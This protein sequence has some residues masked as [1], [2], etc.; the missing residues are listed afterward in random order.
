[1]PGPLPPG[2][3]IPVAFSAGS[4]LTEA[5]LNQ[6]QQTLLWRILFHTH[7]G[8]DGVK[9]GSAALQDGAVGT[10]QMAMHA[11]TRD[12]LAP[13][14][15]GAAELGPAAVTNTH[16]AP[17]AVRTPSIA[18]DQVTLEKLSPDIR[19]LLNKP[20]LGATS[21]AYV[22]YLDGPSILNPGG[23]DANWYDWLV[24][25]GTKRPNWQ[26]DMTRLQ[27]DGTLQ[28]IDYLRNPR[29][30]D[31]KKPTTEKPTAFAM[32][33]NLSMSRMTKSE[34]A[35][36]TIFEMYRELGPETAGKE[37]DTDLTERKRVTL[38]FNPADVKR[39]QSSVTGEL[40]LNPGVGS[41]A[42]FSPDGRANRFTR[43]VKPS[44]DG[45]QTI[46]NIMENYGIPTDYA[47]EQMIMTL[48]EIPAFVDFVNGPWLAPIGYWTASSRN[49]SAVT[50]KLKSGPNRVRIT[51]ATPYK[52]PNYAVTITPD[53]SGDYTHFKV[54]VVVAR[55]NQYVEI[56]F[57][58]VTEESSTVSFSIAVFG[59]LQ[60]T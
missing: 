10:A 33:A 16:L 29:Y 17:N 25:K 43:G 22:M 2:E 39:A 7:N 30:L 5:D 21:Y 8:A 40:L 54:P 27:D 38:R 20:T 3:Q 11:V 56:T 58:P 31:R 26:W 44:E 57:L 60:G 36:A 9:L 32:E 28:P 41:N 34:R 37:L 51:F 1:M 23:V 45:R 19:A 15:V 55:T 47:S 13:A 24:T 49:V 6:L 14:A 46:V 4:P 59:D 50:R 12:R 53:A 18:N 48:L 35:E 42:A 52:Q